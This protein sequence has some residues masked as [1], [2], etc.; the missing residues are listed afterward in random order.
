MGSSANLTSNAACPSKEDLL[1]FSSGNLPPDFLERVG[2]HLSRCTPCL[3]AL[4]G[5]EM[6]ES[7]IRNLRVSL[8]EPTQDSFTADPEYRRM[9]EQAIQLCGSLTALHPGNKDSTSHAMPPPRALGQYQIW[10]KI[11][12][13]G[14]GNVYRA[15]HT[16]G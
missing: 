2:E 12:Q 15:T 14:M 4:A 5:L 10:E 1:A 7:G 13:G 8:T 16:H 3:S 11:G 9:E 6:E